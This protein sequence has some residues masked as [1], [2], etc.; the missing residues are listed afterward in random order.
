MPVSNKTCAPP[1]IF[2]P[3]GITILRAQDTKRK[4][5]PIMNRFSRFL[6]LL[7]LLLCFPDWLSAQSPALPEPVYHHLISGGL[8]RSFIV[9]HPSNVSADQ[10]DP[11]PVVFMFHGSSGNGEKFFRISGWVPKAETEGFLAVFPDGLSYCIEEEGRQKQTTKWND[12]KL[13]SY[14][15]EGQEL[16]DD[17]QFVRDMIAYLDSSFVIDHQRIYASGF[18]NGAG[19]SSRLA[20]ELS[21]T[22]AAVA[23]VGGGL[24]L[25]DPVMD[26]PIPVYQIAGAADDRILEKRVAGDPIPREA[27]LLRA[28]PLIAGQIDPWLS[29]LDL[30]DTYQ[31]RERRKHTTLYFTEAIS[32][33]AEYAFSLVQGL[34]HR[35]PNGRNNP[36]GLV[37]AD[38]FWTFFSR[39]SLPQ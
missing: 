10:A 6:P 24:N 35:Y 23:I 26:R 4:T 29:L 17:V 32:G 39:H 38:L 2:S 25:A 16:P 12:G 8:E 28:D 21:E 15:C 22:L 33:N 14:V 19:F 20:V 30:N 37:A 36:A 34:E 11:L 9:H 3:S 18:S 7:S 31:A 13:A 1:P 5:S 27:A